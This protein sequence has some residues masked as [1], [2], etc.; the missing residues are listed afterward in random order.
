MSGRSLFPRIAYFER[1]YPFSQKHSLHTSNIRKLREFC[2]F[3]APLDKWNIK[4]N[5][6]LIKEKKEEFTRLR[7]EIEVQKTSFTLL[8]LCKINEVATF[9]W[10]LS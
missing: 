4:P 9:E 10:T 8:G 5:H 3:L 6:L 2:I 1:Q 7:A